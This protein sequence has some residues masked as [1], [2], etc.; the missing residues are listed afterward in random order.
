MAVRALINEALDAWL[1]IHPEVANM[2]EVVNGRL[3][4]HPEVAE[5]M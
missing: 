5:K 4:I 2:R 3:A 1:S